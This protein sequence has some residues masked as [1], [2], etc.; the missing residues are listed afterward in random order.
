MCRVQ[1]QSPQNAML[2]GGCRCVIVQ[3]HISAFAKLR[4]F[5]KGDNPNRENTG[6]FLTRKLPS[7]SAYALKSRAIW[8]KRGK[9]LHQ[10]TACICL[11]QFLT[12]LDLEGSRLGMGSFRLLKN[13]LPPN[14]KYTVLLMT[15]MSALLDHIKIQVVYE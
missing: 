6:R 8:K 13:A 10:E 2:G 3:K 15:I 14:P 5:L 4:L 11:G 7:A 12:G 1:K 9:I